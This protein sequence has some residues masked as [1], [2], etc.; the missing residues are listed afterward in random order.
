MPNR[1]TYKVLAERYD[2]LY[3]EVKTSHLV[4]YSEDE[5]KILTALYD[6]EI[7][8]ND[9]AHLRRVPA[10]GTIE[11]I[12]KYGDNS[13]VCITDEGRSPVKKEYS[14]FYELIQNLAQIYKANVGLDRKQTPRGADN[15]NGL[16]AGG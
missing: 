2:S 5:V 16:K 14:S 9:L 4:P 11:D 8:P 6:F 3:T 13:Y 12:L 1:D 15:P 10:A 7:D